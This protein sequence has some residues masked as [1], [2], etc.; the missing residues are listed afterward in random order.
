MRRV[1]GCT[2]LGA[3]VMWWL[4]SATEGI[5]AGASFMAAIF[6]ATVA[7]GFAAALFVDACLEQP[8]GHWWPGPR[9]GRR[10]PQMRCS[11]CGRTKTLIYAIWACES[12][13]RVPIEH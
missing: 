12:C 8:P 11:D 13:D 7:V 5:V 2:A 4:S 6:G 10:G 1:V 3:A 9:F